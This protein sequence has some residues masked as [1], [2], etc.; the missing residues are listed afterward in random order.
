MFF[1]V[2]SIWCGSSDGI[3]IISIIKKPFMVTTV[4]PILGESLLFTTKS[5]RVLV[6]QLLDLKIMKCLVNIVATQCFATNV[7]QP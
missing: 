2:F 7:F 1:S 6:F 5:P 3:M 4:W